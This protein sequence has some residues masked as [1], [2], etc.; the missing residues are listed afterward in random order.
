MYVSDLYWNAEAFLKEL[1]SHLKELMENLY[2]GVIDIGEPSYDVT[3]DDFVVCTILARR[4]VGPVGYR[5]V[6]IF[7]MLTAG[8]V[9]T[10]N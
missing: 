7:A 10:D 9:K 6:F 4:F 3:C 2:A 8:F 1:L 5:E